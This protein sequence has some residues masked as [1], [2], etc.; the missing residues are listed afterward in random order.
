MSIWKSNTGI[1]CC[2]I[3]MAERID[4]WAAKSLWERY[5]SS[6]SGFRKFQ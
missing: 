1:I 5:G 2:V 4:V 3:D 6:S